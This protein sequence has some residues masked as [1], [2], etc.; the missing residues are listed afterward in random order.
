MAFAKTFTEEVKGQ[1]DIVRIVSDYVSLKKRGKNYLA[2]CPFHT[3]K[4]PSFNV[5]P[6]MQIFHCFGCKV[7]GDVFS[8]VMQI[9]HCDFVQAV[10]TVAEKLSIPVPQFEPRAD[11]GKAAQERED[12]LQLNVWATEFFQDQLGAGVEGER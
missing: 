9:E 1:A 12:I 6:A 2:N 11:G 8:F 5:N 7:G 4:T 3:E 10:K